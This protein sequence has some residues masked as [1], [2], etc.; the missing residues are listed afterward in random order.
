MATR[1]NQDCSPEE[2][3]ARDKIRGAHPQWLGDFGEAIWSNIFAA[4]GIP[5]VSLAKICDGGAPMIKRRNNSIVLPDFEIMESGKAAFVDSKAKKRSVV[6]RLKNEER[7]GIDRRNWN[8]YCNASELSGRPCGIAIVECFSDCLDNWSGRLLIETLANLSTPF[9]G[10][11]SE[12]HMIYWPAKRFK[13]LNSLTAVELIDLANGRRTEILTMAL[14][15]I[16][17]PHVQQ[18]LFCR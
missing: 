15:D 7:H 10:I 11:S 9:D 17:W 5:Y 13:H 1:L 18:E 12:K 6:Y 16:F 3:R 8:H 2:T 4:S 14:N